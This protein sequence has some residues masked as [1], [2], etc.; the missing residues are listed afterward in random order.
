MHTVNCKDHLSAPKLMSFWAKLSCLMPPLFLVAFTMTLAK[1]S[2]LP[3]L[4][5]V[6]MSSRLATNSSFE[7]HSSVC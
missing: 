5:N 2:E 1:L 3:L 7:P 4:V 6:P